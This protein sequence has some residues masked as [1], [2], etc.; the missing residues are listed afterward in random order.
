MLVLKNMVKVSQ[1][2]NFKERIKFDMIWF[3]QNI[4][5]YWESNYFMFCFKIR[6]NNRYNGTSRQ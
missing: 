5:T 4:M 1:M 3:I 6:L 2:T